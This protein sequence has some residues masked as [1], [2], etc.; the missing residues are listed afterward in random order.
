M[1]YLSANPIEAAINPEESNG[2]FWQDVGEGIRNWWY[3]FTGQ[4]EKTSYFKTLLELENSKNQRLAADME[5][6]GLSKFGMTGSA[7][8]SPSVAPSSSLP[9][10]LQYAAALMDLKKQKV[11]IEADQAGVRKTA[12]ETAYINAQTAGQ[13]NTNRTFDEKF[14][15][16]MAHSQSQRFLFDAQKEIA[17][18]EG[19]FKA[20]QIT[21]SIDFYVAQTAK[22]IAQSGYYKGLTS[23]TQT[24][25]ELKRGELFWQDENMRSQIESRDAAT[26]KAAQEVLNL[27]KQSQKTAA[28]ITHIIAQTN[29]VNAATQKLIEDTAYRMLE[30]NV[31]VYNSRY[32]ITN[33]LR[34]NDQPTRML[35]I[36][37]SQLA[38]LITSKELGKFTF[39]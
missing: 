33:G 3:N 36:N 4:T 30:Y 25:E 14:Q 19:Q 17:K 7:P 38:N 16:D 22:E 13:E 18:T 9:K 8:G 29:N 11:G 20:E 31:L 5:K 28:E 1:A 21:A 32:S 2:T 12:A 39:R 10:G 6:A 15:E 34:T 27:R 23:L 35:G 24:E 26:R 37:T